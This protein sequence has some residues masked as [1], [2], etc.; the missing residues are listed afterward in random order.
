MEEIRGKSVLIVGYGREGKSVEQFLKVHYPAVSIDITDQKDGKEYLENIEKY[1][2]VIRSPGVPSRLLKNARWVT[3]GTNIFFSRASKLSIGIT[4]TKG[5]STTASLI[6]HM[7]KKSQLVGNIG[8]PMLN[9]LDGSTKNTAFVVELSSHQLEDVR[10]SPHIAVLLPIV[11]EH[12]DYYKNFSVYEKAKS[13]I[14]RFQKKDDVVFYH[15]SVEKI[16]ALSP[17]KKI[18]IIPSSY[19]SPLLGNQTNISAAVAVAKYFGISENTIKKSLETFTPLP[20]RLE[21][22]GEFKNIRFYNDS[23]A[24]IPEATIHALEA[25]PNVDTLIAGGFD[26]GLSYEKLTKFL[27]E[28]PIKTLILFPDTG[29]RIGRDVSSKK[30]FVRTMKEAIELAYQHTPSGGI[31]L[32]SPASA[33]F[34]LFRDYADRGDQFKEWVKKI[35]KNL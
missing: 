35:G 2:T 32:L 20:H 7:V 21:Y 27:H 28:H 26:R 18:P 6:S 11:P 13:N 34:N 10:Y 17:G 31:C 30:F 4:G 12:L 16:A 14:V 33:S 8:R 3:T 5:K 24:T 19:H 22:V 9:Y 15:P 25:L 29:E 23:L 1:D